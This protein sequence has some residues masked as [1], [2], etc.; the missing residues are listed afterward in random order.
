MKDGGDD[1]GGDAGV[2]GL[3]QR[4]QFWSRTSVCL[5]VYRMKAVVGSSFG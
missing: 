4:R 5:C 2:V 1:V 3:F